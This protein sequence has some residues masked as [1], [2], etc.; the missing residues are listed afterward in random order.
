M[1]T[2]NKLEYM[3]INGWNLKDKINLQYP[4]VTVASA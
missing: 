3:E 2:Y 4:F 1:V